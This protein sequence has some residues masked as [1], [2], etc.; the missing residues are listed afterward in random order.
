MERTVMSQ[1]IL[2]S[3]FPTPPDAS[4]EKKKKEKY[5]N[6]NKPFPGQS[7]SKG[8]ICTEMPKG[9]ASLS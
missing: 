3:R 8:Y 7:F 2:R 4:S 6:L 1:K 9:I 5:L